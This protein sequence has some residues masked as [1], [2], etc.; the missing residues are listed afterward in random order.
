MYTATAR[1]LPPQESSSG[2]SGLLS[3][4]GGGLAR[5]A[6]GFIG[7]KT[8]SD[9][10]VGILKSR[11]VADALIKEFNLKELYRAK[12][13]A[14]VYKMLAKRTNINVSRKDQIIS[15]SVEDP[16]PQR[17]AQ[18]ANTYVDM[19]DQINR[20]V[21]ITEGHR[22]RVF[23]ENRL[24][25]VMEDLAKAEVELKEFQEKY[26]VVAI[27]EQ[28]RV[29]IEGAAR[30]KG[31]IIVAQ[32]ELEVLKEFGTER[33]NE[34]IMLKA[35]IA[36]LQS[37]LVRI[38]KGNPG[39]GDSNFYLPFNELPELGMRLARLMRE[40]KIQEKV[41][42]LLSGQYELAKIEEAKDVNTIQVLDP[43][44]P[45]DKKSRPKRRLIVIITTFMGFFFAVL[46]AFFREYVERIKLEDKERYEQLR[47]GLRFWTSK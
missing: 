27:E 22:K 11:T 43:A 35:K 29:A 47:Q 6:G 36:E 3:G 41:F 33:Q 39:K 46:L 37:Q 1:I 15:V 38:E 24:N 9:L 4:A 8:T 20:T 30:I 18:M 28:A 16:D 21:N 7:G 45:P 19:L 17:A 26:K 14:D 34:A 40:A 12:Y 5:L 10:Y 42:E 25:K 32:T 44:V 13:L 2:L 23:L 31:E